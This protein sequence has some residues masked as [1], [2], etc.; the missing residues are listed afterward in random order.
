MNMP[1]LR[2]VRAA[3][4]ANVTVLPTAA[5]RQ[6]DNLRYADQRKASRAAR[7]ASPFRERYKCP[8]DREADATAAIIAEAKRT[9]A[10]LIV[11][12]MLGTMPIEQRREVVQALAPGALGGGAGMQAFHYART[13]T[14]NV[15]QQLDL[16][17]A[18]DRR[19]AQEGR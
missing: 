12:A 3:N 7:E 14:F 15:G 11:L 9:P 18:M 19:E 13:T 6:V 2:Q 10:L 1:S 4:H 16:F 17:R 8:H 5:P